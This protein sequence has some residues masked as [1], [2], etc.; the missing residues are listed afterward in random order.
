MCRIDGKLVTVAQLRE[1]GRPAAEHP[2][3]ARRAAAPGPGQSPGLSGPV[4][5]VPASAGGLSGGL[6]QVARHPPGDGQAPDGRGG[7]L[8]P[9]RHPELPDSG[10]GAGPAEGWGGRGALRP[11]DPCC[12]ARAGSWRRSRA[13]SLPCPET[14]TGTGPAP[15]RPG[16]GGGPG[17]V[18]H[19]PG[20]L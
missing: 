16:G 4:R 14:R 10:A 20:A 11:S 1:L 3:P 6:P 9:G 18:L 8:P 12:A 19:Q 15:H 2:R 13:R 17:G 7:A 5:R